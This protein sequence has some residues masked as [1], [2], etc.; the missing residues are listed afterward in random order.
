MDTDFILDNICQ[1]YSRSQLVNFQY[2]ESNITFPLSKI[3][4]IMW[5]ATQYYT[6]VLPELRL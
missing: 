1:K 3:A 4:C 2:N 6:L 5:L